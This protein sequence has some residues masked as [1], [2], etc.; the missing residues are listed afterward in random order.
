MKKI[1]ATIIVAVFMF[2]IIYPVDASIKK[3]VDSQN[4]PINPAHPTVQSVDSDLAVT[5]PTEEN[6]FDLT[7]DEK[8][9]LLVMNS[10]LSYV[11]PAIMDSIDIKANETIKTVEEIIDKSVNTIN[12]STENVNTQSVKQSSNNVIN[13]DIQR[14]HNQLGDC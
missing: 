2:S 10:G 13:N 5:N 1:L 3:I 12:T 7:D 4:L 8:S 6:L 9:V 11:N 14:F